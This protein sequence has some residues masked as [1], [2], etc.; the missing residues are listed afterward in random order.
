MKKI[1]ITLFLIVL[2][3]GCDK[4]A[5]L[6]EPPPE[7]DDDE[8]VIN[9]LPDSN[10]S[11]GVTSND[12][13]NQSAEIKYITKTFEPS[14]EFIMNP[15]RGSFGWISASEIKDADDDLSDIRE[16]GNTI[17][18]ADAQFD[19][20]DSNAFRD[21][22]LSQAF[23]NTL[24]NFF[25]R[26]GNA[27]IK[28]VLRFCYGDVAPDAPL[29]RILMHIQQLKPVLQ[30]NSDVI[31]VLQA[32]FI[33]YWGEWHHT[34]DGIKNDINN[35]DN[36]TARAAVLD[37]LLSALPDERMIQ[38]RRPTFKSAYL[39]STLPLEESTAFSGSAAA[40]I[41]HHNDCFLASNTDYGTYPSDEVE[42]WKDFINQDALFVPVGGETCALNPPKTDCDSAI[43]EMERLH[44]SFVNST[45]DDEVINH[46]KE[47][48]CWNEIMQNIGYRLVL[49]EA[50][51]N[52]ATAP[53]EILLLK[54]AVIN[55]GYAPI[56]NER[57]IYAILSDGVGC[58]SAKLPMYPR[59]WNTNDIVE[60]EIALKMPFDIPVGTYKLSV[61]L[62][63]KSEVLASDPF[64]SIR[65]ANKDMW[66]SSQGHNNLTNS[67]KVST[68]AINLNST[69]D[70]AFEPCSTK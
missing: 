45:Y 21:K 10:I 6:T 49:K 27:G 47:E 9:P 4:S 40:R 67:F 22:P 14:D 37:A 24:S 55:K 35:L 2:F 30:A 1:I 33:G 34:K 18:F 70:A 57:P 46:W 19:K 52:E 8:L 50:S 31:F 66:D 56:Y 38:V 68:D 63:D 44:W 48:G 41:G 60:S 69:P 15:E 64:Y 11:S 32:G 51:W 5:P 7:G 58:Y 17:A 28:L 42:F 39:G 26:V 43:A 36:D 61:W 12:T 29:S 62:P 20:F 25:E 54:L 23:L 13:S 53:N 59:D 16:E 3:C 65:F